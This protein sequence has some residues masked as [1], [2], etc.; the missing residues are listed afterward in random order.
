MTDNV[1][2]PTLCGFPTTTSSS[3]VCI[4]DKINIC[5]DIFTTSD[6]CFTAKADKQDMSPSLYTVPTLQF[7]QSVT[8]IYSNGSRFQEIITKV[9]ICS[10]SGDPMHLI[11]GKPNQYQQ[12]KINYLREPSDP[13]ISLVNSTIWPLHTIIAPKTCNSYWIWLPLPFPCNHCILPCFPYIPTY[14]DPFSIIHHWLPTH[15]G[16]HNLRYPHYWHKMSVIFPKFFPSHAT[17]P[18]RMIP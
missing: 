13:N 16:K 7:G 18:S 10:I 6:V 9:T 11:E 3:D 5:P 4:K 2:P 15:P 14:L 1:Y 17:K 8:H 12:A